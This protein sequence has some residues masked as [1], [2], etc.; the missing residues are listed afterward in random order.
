MQV[1]WLSG[2]SA[3]FVN[4]RPWVQIPAVPHVASS[5]LFFHKPLDLWVKNAALQHMFVPGQ[6][7]RQSMRLLISGSWVRAPHRARQGVFRNT[8]I[9]SQLSHTVHF[10]LTSSTMTVEGLHMSFTAECEL[11]LFGYSSN[12]RG[13][14]LHSKI[15][16]SWCPEFIATL[17]I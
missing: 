8:G 11:F 13:T 2:Q 7:S 6:L 5:Y 10:S 14:H 1:L 15:E 9:V 17:F 12:D 4:R 16:H 3:C